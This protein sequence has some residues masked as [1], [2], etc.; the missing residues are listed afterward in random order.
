MVVGGEEAKEK[1]SRNRLLLLSLD[2]RYVYDCCIREEAKDR[3]PYS[4][5]VS[6]T[7]TSS[8]SSLSRHHCVKQTPGLV[9]S[10]AIYTLPTITMGE[11]I[12]ST[13]RPNLIPCLILSLQSQKSWSL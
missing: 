12:M 1:K 8:H 9:T 5:L 10:T 3:S 2:F 7:C 13:D 6:D 4:P 11:H